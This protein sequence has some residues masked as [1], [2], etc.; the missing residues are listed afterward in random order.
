VLERWVEEG[1]PPDGIAA[2]AA[3]PGSARVAAALL[4]PWPDGAVAGAVAGEG[5]AAACRAGR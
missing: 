3:D 4:C 5:T 2:A 1:R